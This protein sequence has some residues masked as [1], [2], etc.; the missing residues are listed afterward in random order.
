MVNGCVGYIEDIVYCD[1]ID[2]GAPV[3]ILVKFE[4]YYGPTLEN[5]CVPITRIMKSWSV[6]NIYCTRYQFPLTLAYAVTIHKCQGLTLSRIV[7]HFDN[8]EIMTGIFYVAMSRVREKTDLMIAGSAIQSPLFS[9]KS[10]NYLSK[11]EGKKW[12]MDRS[13]FNCLVRIF[14]SSLLNFILNFFFSYCFQACKF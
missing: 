10:K 7:L 3:F 2:S 4:S 1:E 14:T 9:M 11:I 5:G 13:K 8:A 6:N 12:L